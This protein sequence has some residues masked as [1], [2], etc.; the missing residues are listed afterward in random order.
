MFLGTREGKSLSLANNKYFPITNLKNCME[1]IQ[2]LTSFPD[3]S[4]KAISDPKS[5][6]SCS[7]WAILTNLK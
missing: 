6:F 3:F 2:L 4:A 1:D 7:L 5:V